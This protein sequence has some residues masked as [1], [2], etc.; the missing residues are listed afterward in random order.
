MHLGVA[1]APD[2]LARAKVLV[3]VLQH[4]DAVAQRLQALHGG[5][6]H[7]RLDVD[8]QP[9]IEAP[10]RRVA[11][12]LRVLAV[13][14]HAHQCLHVALGLH[15]GAHHAIAHDGLPVLRDK[16]WN[17]GV[18]RPLARRHQIGPVGTCRVGA[19]PEAPVLQ[20]NA[21]RGLHAARAKA[22]EVALDEA[23]HHAVLV[24]R[25]E[26]DGAA[27]DRVAR[28]KILRLV[29]ADESGTGSEVAVIE[30]LR[31]GHLHPRRLG[32][33]AVHI[34]KR[35]LHGLDL[36]VLGL[37]PV[38]RQAGQVKL[39][40]DAQ[41]NQGGNALAAGRNLVQRV[42]PVVAGNGR[43]PFGPVRAQVR[44]AEA[45]AVGLRKGSHGLGDFAGVKGLAARGTNGAQGARGGRKLEQLAHLRRAPPG[46]EALR[47]TGLRLQFGHSGGPLLL[48]H[49]GHQVA[50]LGDLDGGCHEVGKRQLAK[51]L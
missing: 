5:G 46:H 30:H 33:I 15:V 12:H 19:E 35:Q 25:C 27:L 40:Q 44:Q 37:G 36:Q 20:A 45:A 16:G 41:R 13:V 2:E 8:R 29:H 43:H 6:L 10:A 39:L 24:G 32:H 51:A 9:R 42:A 23:H 38:H 48:H 22:G 11:G 34:G 18:K 31:G 21:E 17:D 4:V 14:E 3:R 47:K 50:T 26:V 49:H 1:H 7:R 28:P